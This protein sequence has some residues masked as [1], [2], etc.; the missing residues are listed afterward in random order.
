MD[1]NNPN[2]A[3]LA[4][5]LCPLWNRKWEQLES[6]RAVILVPKFESHKL[7]RWLMQRMARPNYRVKLDE[8]GSFVW[9]RCDGATDLAQIARSLHERF[10]AQVE[11][12]SERLS[13]F[14]KTLDRSK[15][16]TWNKPA[17]EDRF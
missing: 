11:P 17:N 12:V 7:G 5:E 1:S 9:L 16:I 6:G 3:E 8:V 14:F 15:A 13:T 10:G 4:T 2:E